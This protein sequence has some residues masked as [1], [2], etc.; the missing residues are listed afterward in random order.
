[1]TL[2]FAL[3]QSLN[4]HLLEVPLSKSLSHSS[5]MKPNLYIGRFA[6]TPTGPLH[7]GSLVAALASYLDAKSHN[8]HWQLRI[9][10]LDPP[11]ESE[12][13]KRLI[14]QQLIDHGLNWDGDIQY[15]S[16][17][18]Q[19]YE[20]ALDKLA[21][22]HLTF[23]CQ[24]SRKQLGVTGGKHVSGP[25]N[26]SNHS[27]PQATRIAS[28]NTQISFVDRVY[29]PQTQN[30]AHYVGDFVLKR[31]EGLYAYQLA[32]VVD[33]HMSGVTHVV[34]GADLLD[35]TARQIFLQQCLDIQTPSY[36]HLPLAT[37]ETGQ[38]LSKQNMATSLSDSKP[39]DNLFNALTFLG[40]SP[41]S[42][43]APLDCDAQLK[44]ALT[45]WEPKK[46]EPSF[47]GL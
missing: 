7:F 5:P 4:L 16:Q 17:H 26:P 29:G 33:D 25:C 47:K 45:H 27:Q 11:R 3:G 30:L 43:L 28:P 15:Q 10:D 6:P 35:N 18:T 34:R 21:R 38:K 1:M 14:P 12:D 41:P 46:I 44:W 23:P 24:C 8:G 42:H 40:L 2:S 22:K 19:R 39:A 13:A 9:E 20:Q 37:N 31:K 32:V 36:L